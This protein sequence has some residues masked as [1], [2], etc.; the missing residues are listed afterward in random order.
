MVEKWSTMFFEF[1]R[2]FIWDQL[3]FEMS[4]PFTT[5]FTCPHH[6]SLQNPKKF[7]TCEPFKFSNARFFIHIKQYKTFRTQGFLSILNSIK[8]FERDLLLSDS[9]AKSATRKSCVFWDWFAIFWKL[10]LLT[11]RGLWQY[12][13]ARFR[14]FCCLIKRYFV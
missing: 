11:W 1:S 8:L 9:V 14:P 12:P 6:F 2:S 5:H 3:D 13:A 7:W 4:F 10:P